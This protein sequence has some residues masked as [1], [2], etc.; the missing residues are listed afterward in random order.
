MKYYCASIL[1]KNSTLQVDTII[2]KHQPL[3]VQS[4]SDD[5]HH[6]KKLAYDYAL[7]Q[8]PE[9]KGWEGHQS[10]LLE[11]VIAPEL[12]AYGLIGGE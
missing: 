4:E 1:A 8:W 12:E 10:V 3:L 2:I 11:I 5:L 9:S 6:A 7:K